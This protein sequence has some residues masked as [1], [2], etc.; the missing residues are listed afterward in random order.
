VFKRLIAIAASLGLAATLLV[1]PAQAAP[2]VPRNGAV[3]F[4]H[5]RSSHAAEFRHI[6]PLDHAIDATPRGETILF[7]QYLF[8]V[9][10][11]ANKLISA[12]RRGVHVKIIMDDGTNT[13]QTRK[14]RSALNHDRDPNSWYRTCKRS[15]MSNV[16]SSTMHAKLY[17]F[18]KTAGKQ[19]VSMVSSA[20]P[21]RVN[22]IAS[23]NNTHTWVGMK[24]L[25][26]GLAH[27]FYEMAKDKNQ[28]NYGASRWGR[29]TER[30]IT[31]F[32][33]PLQTNY[34]PVLRS[35]TPSGAQAWRAGTA[36]RAAPWCG[37]RTGAGPAAGTTWLGASGS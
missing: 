26:D 18:S 37:S 36:T 17:L 31:L 19:W 27:Y 30:N 35:S 34:I 4:N 23:W 11:T 29:V 25:Y 12:A 13:K 20:N 10:A 32:F 15:C 7:A 24:K 28:L 22:T 8:N 16:P 33:F 21:H 14:L 3:Y 6:A 5:P 2:W 1:Q 9:D